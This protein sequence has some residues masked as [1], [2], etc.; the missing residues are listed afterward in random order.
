M[1][2]VRAEIPEI[3]MQRAS[4]HESDSSPVIGAA[5][6]ITPTRMVSRE[7]ITP[8]APEFFAVDRL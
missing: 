4:S 2:S 1:P 5:I 6:K 7:E 3:M 8:S